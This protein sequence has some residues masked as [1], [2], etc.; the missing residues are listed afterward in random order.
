MGI[1]KNK[2]L[3]FNVYLRVDLKVIKKTAIQENYTLPQGITNTKQEGL[4]LK[5][6][7]LQN[8]LTQIIFSPITKLCILRR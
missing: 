1:C 4:M 5:G 8:P 7:V 2:E 3:R 6:V